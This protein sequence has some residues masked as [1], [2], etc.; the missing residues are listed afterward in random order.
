[1]S[2]L[3]CPDCGAEIVL[4]PNGGFF[5]PV[6]EQVKCKARGNDRFFACK[7]AMDTFTQFRENL[8]SG[9]SG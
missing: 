4:R 9:N 2:D 1:M 6:D 5:V 7:K 3:T 8:R